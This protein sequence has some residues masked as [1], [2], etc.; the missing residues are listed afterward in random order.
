MNH[1]L[2]FDELELYEY[3]PTLFKPFYINMEP[4]TVMRWFRFLIDCY[5]GF[6]V[7]Y[8]KKGND[9]IGYCTITSGKNPRFWFANNKD[10]VIGPY[11]ID[12]KSRG[13]GY[14]T[15]MVDM[16]I[17]KAALSWESAYLYILNTNKPSIRVAEKLGGKLMF[18]VHNT[19]YRKLVKTESGEY[20]VYLIK[21]TGQ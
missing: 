6:K 12:E 8:L 15:V 13:K 5:F 1:I 10:I 20:G 3:V 16:V 19:F 11:Y 9:Y 18:H 14:S 17:H 21:G 7:Y 2:D 4:M